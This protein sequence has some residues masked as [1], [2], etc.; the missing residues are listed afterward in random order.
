MKK[1]VEYHRVAHDCTFQIPS[2][3]SA[4][5]H[6]GKSPHFDGM[7][8]N[9]W[10]RKMFGY[11]SAIHKDLWKTVEIGC[12]IPDDY[13]TPTPV[14]AYILQRNYQ[15]LNIL[16][17][18]IS[19]KEFDKIEDALTTKDAWDTLQVNHHGSRKVRE[20][21][22]K[23]LED[24]LILFSMKKDETIKE[25]Y[26]RMKKIKNQI[27]ALGG[28]KWGDRE[29]VD[30]LLTV[31]MSRDITLPSLIRAER[32]FKHF[33]TENVLGRIE[34]HHDQLKRLALQAKLKGKEKATQ[35]SKMMTLVIMKMMS[36][37]MSKW[38]SSSRTLEGF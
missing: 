18:S 8:Y 27:K 9:Q 30:K 4:S 19:A 29:I 3:H 1:R 2:E 21:R 28:D 38:L 5:I 33:T 31:Y 15:A 24:G 32:G 14:Q 35:S 22:I 37:M 36:L 26:N 10:K 23:T 12:D 17:S 25:M 34:T 13:E 20:S 11:L 7:G 6:M 16:H